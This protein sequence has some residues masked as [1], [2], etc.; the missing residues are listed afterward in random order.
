[1]AFIIPS[2]SSKRLII[3]SGSYGSSSGYTN[4]PGFVKSLN[5][6]IRP[7]INLNAQINMNFGGGGNSGNGSSNGGGV[8]PFDSNSS[9][10]SKGG[11]PNKKYGYYAPTVTK[12]SSVSF[13]SG[14]KS[15]TIINPLEPSSPTFGSD[16][17]LL[18]GTLLSSGSSSV[19]TEFL[20]KDIHFNLLSKVQSAVNYRVGREFT[21]ARFSKYINRLANALQ[22]YYC[23]DTVLAYET[24]PSNTN[25]GM[26]GL[27][28]K[29]DAEILSSHERLKKSLISV[30]IPPNLLSFVAYM[31]QTFRFDDT[32][33]SPLYK[34][35]FR[36]IFHDSKGHCISSG[37]YNSIIDDLLEDTE[38]ISLLH[39][40]FPSMRTNDLVASSATPI[41]DKNF[42]SFW[43]NSCCSY[44]DQDSMSV[45]F[46]KTCGIASEKLYYGHFCENDLDGLF[47]ACNTI[48]D[49]A[50]AKL[51]PGIWTP[52]YDNSIYKGLTKNQC[53]NILCYDSSIDSFVAPNS[54][55]VSAQ[56]GIFNCLYYVENAASKY[57]AD[58]YLNPSAQRVQLHNIENLSQAV[59]QSVLF[60]FSG[61]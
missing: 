54:S 50:K 40:T 52:L 56:C 31:Y 44:F 9:K 35:E 15:G 34:L 10:P 23:V 49:T 3:G 28:T 55:R 48:F 61:L 8:P 16:M 2:P 6:V 59:S 18:S 38:I 53:T 27:R 4:G 24:I 42:I 11:R 7:G 36:A 51:D 22:L 41:Y 26:M 37:Y 19:Y 43:Y 60:L 29:L 20:S 39:K 12:T 5:S 13:N 57:Y 30:A 46:T 14:I 25:R 32:D 58:E 17:F 45:K 1:M 33:Y 21:S 47:Y